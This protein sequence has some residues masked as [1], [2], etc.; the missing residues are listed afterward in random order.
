MLNPA[1]HAAG[2]PPMT[3]PPV[4]SIA[5]ACPLN[6]PASTARC[7]ARVRTD[8]HGAKPSAAS[9]PSGY[10]PSDLQAAYKL[11]AGPNAEADLGVYRSQFALPACTTANGCFRKVD[12]NGGTA[13]PVPNGGW[14][15]EISLD[16]DM[17]SAICPACHILLVEARSSGLDDLGTAVNTAVN[18]GAAVI[19]NSYGANEFS[20][21]TSYDA[22]Y[23]KHSGVAIVAS[24][25]DNGYGVEY[26]ASSQYVTAVGGTSLRTAAGARGWTETVWGG[27]GSGCSAY[28]PKP[29]WQTDNGC[30]RRTVADVSAVADPNTGV[31]VYDSYASQGL[32]GWLMFGGTSV[33]API[34]G[35]VYALTGNPSVLYGS[36]PYGDPSGLFDV[37]F[38]SNGSCGSYLCTAGA[39]YDGPTGLGTPN[40]IAAF[41][42]AAAQTNPPSNLIGK[43]QSGQIQLTWTA[44]STSGAV[45]NVYRGAQSGQESLY[46]SS[47]SGASYA[48]TSVT[49]GATYW[50]KV[51]AAS[52]GN[53][54]TAS[55]EVSV[56]AANGTTSPPSNLTAT[57]DT[58]KV[59]LSWTASGTS[60]ATY[61]VYRGFLNGSESLYVT[62]VTGTT[63]TDSNLQNPGYWY[64]VTAVA[65]GSE[66]G[67]SNEVL[68]YLQTNSSPPAPPTNLTATSDTSK[69][70]LSWTASGT[71]GVTYNVYRGFVNGSE[72]LYVT[73]V[74][75]TTFTDSNLQS[76]GYWYRVTAK[77]SGGESGP[78]N[79]VLIYLQTN[80]SPP[81]APTNLAA[82]SDTSKIS[83]SWTAS[84]TAGVTYNVYRGFLNGS[85][86]LYVTGVTGT[87]FTDSNLQNPGYWYKVTAKSSG[88][89][90]GP[91]N[92][93]LIYLQGTPASAMNLSRAKS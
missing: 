29:S 31:S 55:N 30:S 64:K 22:S 38:G 40:G 79:E 76:P 18:M 41:K 84:G 33:A 66:S 23:Y 47:V 69:I 26:P 15:Q 13:Y 10:H 83:L 63:F 50:Y 36:L 74:T 49:A 67:A 32:S 14:A 3:V 89:E 54:S 9:G 27:S 59:S 51:T 19:S 88:G 5:L 17:V 21:E 35:A 86:P 68:I 7:H 46:K 82:T 93:V 2:T 42:A 53:E 57:S 44:S 48:D 72:S 6:I 81:A 73:G 25:G 37:T 62:G 12:Q 78:S 8:I 90:S 91:S 92:E 80:S 20:S 11:A 70:S 1:V 60:G 61:N 43:A 24:S 58:S 65:N 77:S 16:L 87:T 45:Y 56:L 4:P 71:A 75:G 52:N 85:E 39:G 34:I 28:E